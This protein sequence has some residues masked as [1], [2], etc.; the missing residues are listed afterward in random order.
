[1]IQFFGLNVDIDESV[2]REAEIRRLFDANIVG[3]YVWEI[4]GKILEANDAF[5][6][7]I[8]YEREDLRSGRLRWTDLTPAEWLS[9]VR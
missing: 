5:L 9:R 4:E 3:I 1:M 7:M 2:K 8:G 6:R